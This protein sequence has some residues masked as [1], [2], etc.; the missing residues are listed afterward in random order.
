VVAASLS[1]QGE[2]REPLDLLALLPFAEVE[3][4]T[5][6]I[7][8]GTPEARGHL[9]DGWSYDESTRAGRNF[10]WGRGE[11]SL[12]RLVV[13]APRDLELHFRCW[14]LRYQGAPPQRLTLAIGGQRV[15][16]L[17]L[18]PAPFWYRLTL[19][20]ALLAPGVNLLELRYA[21]Q[22]RPRDVLPEA[23][24][25]RPLAVAWDLL[26]VTNAGFHGVPEARPG[27]G[28]P[29]LRLPLDSQVSF[30][31]RVPDGSSLDFDSVTPWSQAEGPAPPARLEIDLQ[32]ADASATRPF[33]IQ[34]RSG[35][36]APPPVDLPATG[37]RP[38]RITLRALADR[39]TAAGSMGLD[40]VRPR[41]MAPRADPAG[42]AAQAG[43]AG[44]PNIIVY[45]IDALRRDH[46]GVY[47]YP[48]GTTPRID[49]FAR[50]AAVFHSAVAQA[51]WTRPAVASIFT[52]LN[53]PSHGVTRR[54]SNLPDD[55]PVLPELLREIGYRTLAVVTNG[56]VSQ[57]FGFDR[58]FDEFHYL[59]EEDPVTF[60]AFS[61][62]AGD[63][64]IRWL[65]SANRD[66][67]FFLYLHTTDPHSPHTPPAPYRERFAPQ[68]A[69]PGAWTMPLDR[70]RVT[71][72]GP[73][74]GAVA[75]TIALYDGEV[76]FNDAQFGVL[77]DRL[78]ELGLYES[79]LIVLLSDHGEA[80]LD[81]GNQGHGTT[82][83]EEEIAIPLLI[84]LPEGR[85]AST[86]VPDVVRQIDILPTLLDQLG[87]PPPSGVQGRS[88]L[89]RLR[90]GSGGEAPATAFSHLARN[91]GEWRS[92]TDGSHK[93]IHSR[94]YEGGGQRIRLYQTDLDPREYRDVALERPVWRGYLQSQ[95]RRLASLPAPSEAGEP[96]RIPPELREKL[97][98]LGYL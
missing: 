63:I 56:N 10:V 71:G 92:A 36:A 14:P 22:Q 79:S 43:E 51:P 52:G 54:R 47:G 93:L 64:A 33:S 83:F 35:G 87:H 12:L 8:F 95:L 62:R 37:G 55:L 48:R 60:H 73:A 34:G 58:G 67:P 3:T 66:Q 28:S 21:W 25:R 44:L 15:A 86:A 45:L 84:K 88:L 1:C 76:A 19:P 98:A 29:A 13:G 50:D 27:G 31:L 17:T 39:P 91:R 40:L 61:D 65:E 96:A 57:T 75:D 53:P 2:P 30:Y 9:L 11:R 82:L 90:G 59:P 26:E 32:P 70:D 42:G 74:P 23:R 80:F 5:R 89:P 94:A 7:D 38:L 16:E 69:N 97:E 78:R 81:H 4:E 20:G 6:R 46:L 49:A 41:V 68:V 85:G 72:E 77:M 24:D 18:Q